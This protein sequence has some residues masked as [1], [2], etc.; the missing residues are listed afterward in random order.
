MSCYYL[1][2]LHNS[3]S[4]YYIHT[5]MYIHTYMRTYI[6]TYIHAY[7]HIHAYVYIQYATKKRKMSF[8]N[9]VDRGYR[10]KTWLYEV[11]YVI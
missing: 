11:F 9:T 5:C 3:Y 10:C 1:N 2:F 4:M 8:L 6:C 7:V